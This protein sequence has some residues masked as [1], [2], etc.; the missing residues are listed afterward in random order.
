[1]VGS[2]IF[3]KLLTGTFSYL[4]LKTNENIGQNS[5]AVQ[6][7]NIISVTVNEQFSNKFKAQQE[8]RKYSSSVTFKCEFPLAPKS[9][10]CEST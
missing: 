7:D 6:I 4:T 10:K 8:F 9:M 3:D 5:G 1:L 2:K